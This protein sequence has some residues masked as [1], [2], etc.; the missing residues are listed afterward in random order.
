MAIFPLQNSLIDAVIRFANAPL[1]DADEILDLFEGTWR[2]DSPPSL[3]V[4][5]SVQRE[6]LEWLATLADRKGDVE[7]VIASIL[8]YRK[9]MERVDSGIRFAGNLGYRIVKDGRGRK[10]RHEVTWHWRVSAASLR[11]I[12]GLAVAS[13]Y[14]A[15]LHD[16]VGQCE[17]AKCNRYFVDRKSRGS[18]RQFCPDRG[19]DNAARQ[20]R[21]RDAQ[22]QL[23]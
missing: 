9:N 1:D 18:P 5:R 2:P 17:W 13:I 11:A 7:A 3:R 16:R 10:A 23:K 14:Q 8:G 21:W 12:C 15:D 22:K 19:C 6:V 20:Q 4:C